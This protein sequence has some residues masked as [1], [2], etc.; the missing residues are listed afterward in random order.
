[1][2]PKI[3][4]PMTRVVPPEDGNAGYCQTGKVVSVSDAEIVVSIQSDQFRHMTFRRKDGTDTS[5][6][7][8]FIV[9]P[10]FLT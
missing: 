6:M 3:G 1:M 10:D 2:N 7:G 8:S 5:G 9:I 4:D